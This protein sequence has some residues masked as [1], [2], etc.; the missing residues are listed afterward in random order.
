MTSGTAEEGDDGDEEN[1][2]GVETITITG[3]DLSSFPIRNAINFAVGRAF[4]QRDLPDGAIR[5]FR[6][7]AFR[8]QPA[9]T[10]Q[11]VFRRISTFGDALEGTRQDNPIDG[12]CGSSICIL[13]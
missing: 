13:Q 6:I 4:A 1:N 2:D 12:D 11:F 3:R 10:Q 5:T 7:P 9:F 8:G